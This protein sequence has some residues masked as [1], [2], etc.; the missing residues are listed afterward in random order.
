MGPFSVTGQPNAMGGR[1]VGGLANMLA[2][3][4]EFASSKDRDRVGRFWNAP[5]LATQPGLKSVELFEAI[6]AG[7]VKAIWIMATNPVD[8]LPEADR[9]RA[10][11]EKCEFVAV[12][13]MSARTDTGVYAHVRLPAAGWGE[14][15]GTVTNSERRISRQRAFLDLPGKAKPDW[16]IV[17]E[18]ARRMGF[19][20]AFDYAGPGDIF[21]EHAALS[22]FENNGSRDFDLSGLTGLDAS[23]YEAMAPVQWPVGDK[24]AARMFGDGRYFTDNGKARFVPVMPPQ[25]VKPAPGKFVLNTGRV[26]DHWHTMT[27]TGKAARLSAHI[28]E[29]FAELHPGDAERLGVEPAGLVRLENRH[30]SVLVRALISPRQ[31][32]G[33]VFVPMHWTDQF[34]SRARIDTLVTANTDP[35]S[36]QPALKMAEVSIQAVKPAWYGFAIARRRPALS[37]IDYWALA[38]AG[39]GVRVE[40]AGLEAPADWDRFVSDLFECGSDAGLLSVQDA[41][42]GRHNFALFEDG[43]VVFALF[44]SAE[45]VAV[46]RTWAAAQLVEAHHTNGRARLLAGRPGA[47]Q[48]DTGAIVC[49]CFQVGVNSIVDAVTQGG[50]MSVDQVGAA[51]KAGTNCGSCRSEIRGIIDAN[52]LQAA[53]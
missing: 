15:D 26:R 1:E 3:H 39:G 12:S 45:P 43:E 17:S 30:G 21:A 53:E 7:R 5:N 14:K 4:M 27:R 2:A 38:E 46:S 40:L 48:P 25:P 6:E 22:A 35:H 23:A 8:S 29:P 42:A 19:A 33:S 52:R 32:P 50:C 37:G 16:W 18:V 36:G 13:D 41:R 31:R 24:S 20:D 28:A 47:D 34:S 11:L 10:A 49:A 9:V 44:V 51:L